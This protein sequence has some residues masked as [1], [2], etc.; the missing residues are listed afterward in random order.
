MDLDR[1]REF[2]DVPHTQPTD[3]F[4]RAV[5]FAADVHWAR[6]RT[7]SRVPQ[8]A[9]LLAV[10]ALVLEDGGDEDEAI[11]GLLHDVVEGSGQPAA[12]LLERLHADFG[13]RVAALVA[14]CAHSTSD[15]SGSGWSAGRQHTIDVL[16]DADP[17]AARIMLADELH[18]MRCLL[19]DL[20]D[21]GPGLWDW[22]NAGRD[23]QLWYYA[24]LSEAAGARFRND[25]LRREFARTVEQLEHVAY[26]A[27]APRNPSDWKPA[28]LPAQRC[29]DRH[30]L[31]GYQCCRAAGHRGLHAKAPRPGDL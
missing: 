16:A 2:T 31:Y 8:L 17:A 22:F 15:R 3:R 18:N 6:S 14:A 20:F 30:R 19:T 11:A 29:D 25:R 4:T 26:S 9:H 27:R 10:A 21:H 23:D 7:G 28:G 13:A 24:A 1:W 12:D 5:A